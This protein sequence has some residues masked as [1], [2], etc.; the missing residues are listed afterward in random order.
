[1]RDKPV[2]IA[3]WKMHK[4]LSETKAFIDALSKRDGL[5]QAWVGITPSFTALST[6]ASL[7]VNTPIHIG[8]QTLHEQAKGAFT[9]EVSARQIREA[10]G[11]FVLIGHSERRHVYKESD[12]LIHEKLKIALEEGLKPILCIGETLQERESGQTEAVLERQLAS[13][14]NGL[15]KSDSLTIAYEPVWA[16]GTGVVASPEV[17]QETQVL[18]RK[19][20]GSIHGEAFSKKISILYGGSVKP[21]NAGKLLSE[22][23]IDGALI[24]G[25]SLDVQSFYQIIEACL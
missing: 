20:I 12:T 25:A 8:A 2:L 7:A 21:E 16:I 22:P 18:S 23:D 4:N 17:A 5:T 1:M 15:P 14:L 3:N 11:S 24:G 13:A 10:G 6:A 19:I 9:G